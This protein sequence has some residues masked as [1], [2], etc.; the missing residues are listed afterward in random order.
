MTTRASHDGTSAAEMEFEAA[1]YSN[2]EMEEEWETHEGSHYSN[3]YSNPEMEWETPEGHPFSNPYTNPEWEEEWETPEGHPFSNPY[4][5]PEWEEEW[6][7]PEGSHY[8]NPYSNPEMEW[9]TAEGHPYSN[10]YTNPEW[11]YEADRFIPLIAGAAKKLIPTA[12]KVGRKLIRGMSRRPGSRPTRRPHR[13]GGRNQQISSLFYQLGRIFAQGESEASALEA[14]LFGANEFETEVAAHEVA[15]QAAL[16][17]VMAAEAAHTE[18]ES[19]AQALLSTVL[20]VTIHIMSAGPAI[21]S[22]TPALVKANSRLVRTLHRQGPAGRQLVRTVP[23][24]VRRT[25]G[26]LKAADRKGVPI[27]PALASKVM[28]GQ[29]ARV[30][31]TPD[32]CRHA[33]TRNMI[34]RQ[35]TVAPGGP[36]ARPGTQ[37]PGRPGYHSTM[38]RPGRPGMVPRRPPAHPGMRMPSRRY[39]RPSTRIPGGPGV[40]PG[41]RMPGRG[42]SRPGTRVADAAGVRPGMRTPGRGYSRPGTRVAGGPGIRSGMRVPRSPLARPGVRAQGGPARVRSTVSGRPVSHPRASAPVSRPVSRAHRRTGA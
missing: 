6:E 8:S 16:T 36:G 5:N 32:I 17:E 20:P 10:P 1:H 22:V 42:Y 38:Y 30:L 40:R 23:T 21:R 29:A 41:M 11:E 33:L 28:T 13:A 26:S 34:V 4:T 14:H 31:A 19:E 24:A 7:T 18:S 35:Q 2:P 37:V 3:P 12:V 25:I 9:E 39:S 15:H 27:T